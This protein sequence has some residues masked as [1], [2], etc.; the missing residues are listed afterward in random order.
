MP[1]FDV[2]ESPTNGL[3]MKGAVQDQLQS[4]VLSFAKDQLKGFILNQFGVNELTDPVGTKLNEITSQL[5]GITKQL[6]TVQTSIDNT[7]TAVKDSTFY[8]ALTPLVDYAVHVF[9]LYRDK[10]APAIRAEI[11]YANAKADVPAGSTC[12]QTRA[13]DSAY[14]DFFGTGDKQGYRKEF[15][16]AISG[17]KYFDLNDTIHSYLVKTSGR[18][19][20][21]TV[22]GAFLMAHNGFLTRATS[23]QLFGLYSYF[24]DAEALATWMKLEYR[25]VDWGPDATGC[26]SPRHESDFKELLARTVSGDPDATPPVESYFQQELRV[27]PP[28]IPA[29]AVISLSPDPPLRTT[30]KDRPMWLYDP[31][32]VGT[33]KAWLPTKQAV[34]DG[35]AEFENT[36]TASVGYALKQINDAQDGGLSDWAIP[37]QDEWKD[38]FAGRNTNQSLGALLASM[39]PTDSYWHVVLPLI[40]G[41]QSARVWTRTP[42]AVDAKCLPGG[43]VLH[44][45]APSTVNTLE[46][47]SAYTGGIA[48]MGPG[49]EVYGST[50]SACWDNAWA[51]INGNIAGTSPAGAVVVARRS[52]GAV[53]YMAEEAGTG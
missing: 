23:D 27:L 7:Y 37:T 10:F 16:T 52:T 6:T 49:P 17:D 35:R 45:H 22:Y 2:C 28:L 26:V 14:N 4:L 13:C 44:L 36:S 24:A 1:R 38:L 46:L 34:L 19:S 31:Q 51:R 11:D 30:A 43:N 21:V 41:S 5:S 48:G 25:A 39:D 32:Y 47:L 50:T 42:V 9:S 20:I 15:L 18:S 40:L 53:N 12:A 8:T 3:T 33:T 29:H